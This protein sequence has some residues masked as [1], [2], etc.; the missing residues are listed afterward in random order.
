[1]RS[2]MRPTA[3]AMMRRAITSLAGLGLVVS[4]LAVHAQ[5]SSA[6]Q[7]AV[8]TAIAGFDYVDTSGESR[9]QSA[10]H[11]QRLRAF[12][13]ALQRDLAASG[14][15]RIVP[16]TCGGGPCA[17]NAQLQDLQAEA[18]AA[19]A[20]LVVLGGIHKLSTL[21]QWAKVD[22]VDAD[23]GQVS[24]DR[25]LTFRGDTDEAWARAEAFI[26]RQMLAAAGAEAPNASSAPIKLAVFDFELDD[27]SAAAGSGA[28]NPT[29]AVQMKAVDD[30]VRRLI[31]Q[32]GRYSLADANA[33][34]AQSAKTP[35]CGRCESAIAARLG[36]A[37][38]LDGTVR[39]VSQTEYVVSFELKDA[40]SGEVIEAAETGLR[41]GANYSWSRGAA[42]LL[43]SRLLDK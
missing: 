32:S 30:E 13:A 19:G 33:A 25:L 2:K 37:Q 7:E 3:Q 42:A 31:A 26:G 8:A 17:S 20:R 5:S 11:Q 22:V 34:E 14:K 29:D 24:F 27:H 43:R 35:D 21:V 9:D 38:V 10:E 41:M 1:M 36:A 23:K 6:A 16:I 40:K 28:R 18:R 39:K 12:T 4:P 15:Y